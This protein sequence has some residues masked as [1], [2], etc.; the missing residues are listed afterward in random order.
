MQENKLGRLRQRR[1]MFRI[2]GAFAEFERSI[3]THS[4][5]WRAGCRRAFVVGRLRNRVGSADDP[6]GA[7]WHARRSG[8]SNGLRECWSPQTRET[9]QHSL[10]R[11][12]RIAD[13]MQERLVLR[14]RSSPLAAP[15]GAAGGGG[16]RPPRA[17]P[18][19]RRPRPR[20]GP[21]GDKVAPLRTLLHLS[22]LVVC[23]SE[24]VWRDSRM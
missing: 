17:T 24:A 12:T 1:L 13:K 14:R 16:Q 21:T 6:A 4:R 22:S 7:T 20:S 8:I 2:T 11:P 10:V 23:R 18:S 9:T 5:R 19:L 15:A 3:L